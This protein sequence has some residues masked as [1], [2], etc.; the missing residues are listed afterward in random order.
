MR[1]SSRVL[2]ALAL[3]AFFLFLHLTGT[4]DDTAILSG[5]AS[6]NGASAGLLGVLYILAW[7]GAIV[8]APILVLATGLDR[9]LGWIG[10]RRAAPGDGSARR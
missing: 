1:L 3:V 6:Q 4:R 8:L 2:L 7:F 10:R 5:T 9:G